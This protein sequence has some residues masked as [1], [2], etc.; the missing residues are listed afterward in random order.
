MGA[1]FYRALT[2]QVPFAADTPA[3]AAAI[4]QLAP[5]VP[6]LLAYLVESL[7][8][9]DPA[10]RPSAPSRVAKSLRV[11]LASEEETQHGH[12]EDH[13]APH[14]VPVSA[15]APEEAVPEHESAAAPVAAAG[16]SVGGAR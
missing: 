4:G 2:G 3:N 12:P 10:Q 11:F 7:I 8:D 9:P 14:H 5:E 1:L 6:S 16:Q 13:L 15:P